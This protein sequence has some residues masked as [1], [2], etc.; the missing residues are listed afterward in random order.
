VLT[1]KRAKNKYSGSL[2][3]AQIIDDYL[4]MEAA[5][6]LEIKQKLSQLTD[7]DLRSIS[8]YLLRLRHSTEE[9][10]QERTRIMDE[11][12]Q[13]KKTPLSSLQAE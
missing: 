1:Q 10:R 4:G 9:A 8:A 12:D 5:V 13:G 11:M 2:D 6:E 3:L 7:P